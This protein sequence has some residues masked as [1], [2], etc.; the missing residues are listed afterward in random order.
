VLEKLEYLGIIDENWNIN[1]E[2]WYGKRKSDY[3]QAYE[4]A[5]RL[6]VHK[7]QVCTSFLQR[8]MC[9]GYSKACQFIEQMEKDAIVGARNGVKPRDVLITKKDL[10]R[11]ER[12]WKKSK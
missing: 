7:G 3:K 11:K 9:V 10:A 1:D 8:K 6:A 4:Q 12:E 5:V 2:N